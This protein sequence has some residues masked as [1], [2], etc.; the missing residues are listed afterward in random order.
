MAKT[1][2]Q[3]VAKGRA[4]LS[5]KAATIA[6]NW[7]AAK[8]TMQSEYSLLPFGPQTKAAYNAGVQAASHP[9]FDIEKW[10]RK[11]AAGVSR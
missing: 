3:M 9:G 7:A 2:E 1:I 11:F 10:A 6:S 5:V 8:S 4:K